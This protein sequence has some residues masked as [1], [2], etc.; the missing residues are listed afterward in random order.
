[1]HISASLLAADFACMGRDVE[2]AER[3]GVDSFHFDIMDG[4]YVPNIALSPAHVEALRNHTRLPLH[5]HLELSNPEDVLRT[6]QPWHADSITVCRDT[7]IKP[8][9]TFALVRLQGAAVGLSLSP[10]DAVADNASV[11][12]DIDLL[13]ILAVSPGFGGQTMRPNTLARVAEA[14]QTIDRMGLQ[15]PLAVDGGVTPENAAELAE[16]GADMLIVGTALFGARRM[17]SVVDGLRAIAGA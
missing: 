3:A 9:R 4:H 12:H 1:M 15:M 14:R 2:R 6:F 8:H 7:L 17:S 5:V 11:L 10:T 16:A 13:V